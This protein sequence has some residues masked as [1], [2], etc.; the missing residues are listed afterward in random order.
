M[1]DWLFSLRL[2]VPMIQPATGATMSTKSVSCQLTVSIV[3]KQTKM[4]MG[5]LMSMSIELVTEFSTALTS[6]DIRAMMSPLRSSEKKLSGS[7]S[8][9][10]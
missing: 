8:T 10:S 9:F 5:L 3:A 6:A 2:T 1:V 7:R 4:A